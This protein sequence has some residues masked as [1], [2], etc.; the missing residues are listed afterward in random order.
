MYCFPKAMCSVIFKSQRLVSVLEKLISLM[1]C[2]D[3]EYN[4]DSR[5]GITAVSVRTRPSTICC[6]DLG[7]LWNCMFHI[8]KMWELN[9]LIL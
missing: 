9:Y 3:K 8:Y 5:N 1:M 6:N 7:S 2:T 4:L